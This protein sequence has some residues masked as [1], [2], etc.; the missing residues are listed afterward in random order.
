MKSMS[1]LRAVA[2]VDYDHERHRISGI[3][4]LLE[5]L[6]VVVDSIEHLPSIRGS[7]VKPDGESRPEFLQAIQDIN[8]RNQKTTELSVDLNALQL[9]AEIGAQCAAGKR[10]TPIAQLMAFGKDAAFKS[11][12]EAVRPGHKENAAVFAPRR[13]IPRTA[14]A[15]AAA[16]TNRGKPTPWQRQRELTETPRPNDG[17]YRTRKVKMSQAFGEI[18]HSVLLG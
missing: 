18:L 6:D 14:A 2:T 15:N 10:H 8:L 13:P 17:Y 1:T 11:D 9:G 3:L 5:D 16:V 7:D 4:G 12:N